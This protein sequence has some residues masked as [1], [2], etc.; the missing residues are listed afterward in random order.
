MKLLAVNG[1]P[2]KNQN[3]AKLLG[4]V[5]AGAKSAGADAELV[6]LLGI[7][8]TGC[9]SC[10]ECKRIGGPSYG[11]CAVRDGLRP[12]LDLAH[13]ADVLVLGAPIYL[14]TESAFMRAFLERLT[15]QYFLYSNVK[16][17]LAPRKKAA[18]LLYTMNVDEQGANQYRHIAN[19]AKWML[20]HL[21]A[22]CEI[23]L[24]CDT[25]QFANYAQ[26]DTDIWDEKAKRER[27]ET[28]F[29]QELQKAREL[30]ARLVT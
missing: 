8:Y 18:A 3:T 30:G 28:V 7:Q 15:F 17:P 9:I 26:Y 4:Q 2:R 6:H 10:F 5:V 12:L 11:R 24:S 14:G 1:S 13:E 21:F 27:H 19:T 29:P 16:K 20:E 23:V 25:L 22:P